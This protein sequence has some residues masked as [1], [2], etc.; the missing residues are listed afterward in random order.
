MKYTA[1]RIKNSKISNEITIP[2]S[3][4]LNCIL[5]FWNTENNVKNV[6]SNARSMKYI[7]AWN[8][9]DITQ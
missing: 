6:K 4:S 9:H 8:I 3:F 1:G 5:N 2:Y 7:L